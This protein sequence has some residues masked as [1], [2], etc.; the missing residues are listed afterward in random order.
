M[1]SLIDIADV[2]EEIEVR[3]S[4]VS[5]TGITANGI[6]Q[7]LSQFPELRKVISGRSD[8]MTAEKLMEA[9]PEAVAAAIA[10]GTGAPG[11]K[12]A[13]AKAAGLSLG[14]QVNLLDAIIRLT[15]PAG[16]GPFVEQLTRL[17][18]SVSL[19]QSPVA[20]GGRTKGPAMKSPEQ[21]KD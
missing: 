15:F 19:T 16:L 8:D 3:G 20:V 13:E 18:N 2:S 6:A 10:A 7:L 14:D 9:A 4:L 17:A 5:V 21:S 12:A 1:V 11:D